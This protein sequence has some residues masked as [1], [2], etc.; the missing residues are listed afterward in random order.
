VQVVFMSE[1]ISADDRRVLHART[2]PRLSQKPLDRYRIFAES[3]LEELDG[4]LAM[5]SVLGTVNGS[6]STFA[7]ELFELVSGDGATCKVFGRH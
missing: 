7:H 5:F 3:L 4:T 1:I 6:G 2:E